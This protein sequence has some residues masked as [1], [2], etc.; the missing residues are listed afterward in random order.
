[1]GH[2]HGLSQVQAAGILALM[3]IF[4]LVG[5]TASGW[6]TDRYDPR[7]LLFVYYSLRGLSLIYLPFSRSTPCASWMPRRPTTRSW[8]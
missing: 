4:D 7:C 3:G 8:P 5:T 2:D 1:M 6:L